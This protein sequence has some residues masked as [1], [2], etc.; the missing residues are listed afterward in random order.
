[1]PGSRRKRGMKMVS[2]W[3]GAL[4]GGA[5]AKGTA[6]SG[7]V[8]CAVLAV[9]AS[10][11]ALSCAH[12]VDNIPPRPLIPSG[13]SIDASIDG[14][15]GQRN[16]SDAAIVQNTLTGATVLSGDSFSFDGK[17][18]V[19]ARLRL[20]YGAWSV[21]GRY[22]GGF[23]WSAARSDTSPLIWNFPTIPPL[24]GLG[25][26]DLDSDASG[27]L[28]SF[29]GNL[30]WRANSH[31]VVFAGGRWISQPDRLA[32]FADFVVNA[33]TISWDSDFKAIGP[34]I[35][36]E[37]RLFGPRTSFNPMERVFLDV[38][39]RLGYLWS[40]GKQTFSVVQTVGPPF[41]A[42]GSFHDTTLA[43][44]LGAALGI[45]I[46]PNVELRA[47]YRYFALEDG[48]FAPDL[49]ATTNLFNA[50]IGQATTRV[51]VNAI[52]FGLRVVFP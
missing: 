12:A 39:A 2:R 15:Y 51:A 37:A 11:V 1:M 14:L 42:N 30:R 38:D 9:A 44:E 16:Y 36:F 20:G 28:H 18:G 4:L 31:I 35:G 13:L 32:V 3:P 52:T 33:A 40:S 8:R 21:E 10:L 43:Y 27:R 24:F 45:A 49:I 48:V 25:I 19:D 26:S 29:E 22:F 34:Q 6:W 46:T 50:R 5:C 7:P 23:K 41:G 47:G 17:G